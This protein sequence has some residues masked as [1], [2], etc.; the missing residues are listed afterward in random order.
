ML[1]QRVMSA[2]INTSAMITQPQ[3]QRRRVRENESTAIVM[4]H[5]SPCFTEGM[6]QGE[7]L[8]GIA[9]AYAHALRHGVEC[10]VPWQ[11]SPQTRTLSRL[12]GQDVLKSTPGGDNEAIS[13]RHG[14]MEYKPIPGKVRSGALLVRSQSAAYFADAQAAVRK[15]FAPLVSP[16]KLRGVAG[17]CIRFGKCGCRDNDVLHASTRRFLSRALQSLSGD[18]RQLILFSDDEDYLAG[19]LR[20]IPESRAYRVEQSGLGC[21]ALRDMTSMSELVFDVSAVPWWAAWLSHPCRVVTSVAWR[22]DTFPALP[23]NV[24][25]RW[26]FV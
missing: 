26:H 16:R 18:I 7:I 25:A 15:L 20:E 24:R 11:Y 22:D 3:G 6:Q 9:T 19:I 1:S 17:V 5:I 2:H 21:T 10:R 8:H 14:M 12:I 4:P 23:E 13:Y